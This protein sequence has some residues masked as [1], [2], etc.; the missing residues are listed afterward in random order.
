MNMRIIIVIILLTL[1][2]CSPKI[3]ERT[4]TVSKTDTVF[5]KKNI[6]DT[7]KLNF[8]PN[9]TVLDTNKMLVAPFIASIDSL[10]KIGNKGVEIKASYNQPK[11]KFDFNINQSWIDSIM[12]IKQIDSIKT[13]DVQTVY[14][15]KLE[16]YMYLIFAGALIL[17]VAIGIL[18]A[19]LIK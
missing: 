13:T 6:Y 16:W 11:N 5:V 18:L 7:L 1:A 8:T 19:R 4:V 10:F 9:I 15:N 14:V 2:S 3:I 12:K 17:A